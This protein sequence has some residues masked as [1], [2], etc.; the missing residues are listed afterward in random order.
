MN[1]PGRPFDVS[2]ILNPAGWV[3]TLVL[4]TVINIVAARH[5]VRWDWSSGSRF[6][7]APATVETLH[8]LHERIDL[9]IISGGGESLRRSLGPILQAYR[10]ETVEL[11]IHWV[12]PDRDAALLADMQRRFGLDSNRAEDGR[13]F[14]DAVVVVAKGSRHWFVTSADL[15]DSADETRGKP[16][17]ERALTLGIRHVVD[18]ARARL[19]FTVG[20]GE[21]SLAD[22]GSERDGIG[23]LRDLLQR[24]NFDLGTADANV[25]DVHEPF[26]GCTAVIVAGLRT[27]FSPEES[28]RLR[29]YLL[30]GGSA[31]V[32][33]GP[34]DGAD[35][36]SAWSSG[37]DSVIAPFGIA[38]EDALV[39]EADSALRIP[40]THGEGYFVSVRP[41]PVTAGLSNPSTYP[42]RVALFFARP[43]RHVSSPG[44]ATAA[45]LLVASDRAFG[46][47]DLAG[48]GTWDDVPPRDLD[49]LNGPLVVAMASERPRTTDASVHG[50]RVVVVGSRFIFADDNWRQPRPLH[51]AAY[52]MDNALSWLTASPLVVDIPDKPELMAGMRITDASRI[53][54][55]RYVLVFMPL[56]ALLLAVSVWAWRRSSEGKPYRSVHRADRTGS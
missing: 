12:D 24:S 10:A 44:A 32:A 30:D 35:D 52:F 28:N 53:E 23:A 43:M 50:G 54:I 25:P 1:A 34:G 47:R 4:S 8:S 9:Y 13:G 14:A 19:C 42:P 21:L 38:L 45:D 26:A 2:T 41:H 6:T 40:E 33:V 48:V 18:G 51:G 22:A 7:L 15:F 29:T 39:H 56:A 55:K 31:L 46:K 3:A 37:L 20:H 11:D 16:R 17:E 27:A 49:D 5:M 36:A